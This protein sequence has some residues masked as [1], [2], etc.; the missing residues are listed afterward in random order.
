MFRTTFDN[1]FSGWQSY[2]SIKDT[3]QFEELCKADPRLHDMLGTTKERDAK[4]K[5][6]RRTP[7]PLAK[8]ATIY[9]DLRLLSHTL[10]QFK[11]LKLDDKYSRRWMFP[12]TVTAISRN[13]CEAEITS[14]VMDETWNIDTRE[15]QMYCYT[16]EADIPQPHTVM[17]E[18]FMRRNSYIRHL[19]LPQNWDSLTTQQAARLMDD[20]SHAE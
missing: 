17:D 1:G 10:Y 2:N 7:I 16:S 8:G 18:E 20:F 15:L 9:V 4:I 13:K 5:Q 12:A 11:K 6:L 3:V 14:T 19:Q